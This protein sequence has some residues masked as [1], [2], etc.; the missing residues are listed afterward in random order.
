MILISHCYDFCMFLCA[1]RES[2]CFPT[3]LSEILFSGR[4]TFADFYAF[5]AIFA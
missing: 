5:A 4:F 1:E 2:F 3:L